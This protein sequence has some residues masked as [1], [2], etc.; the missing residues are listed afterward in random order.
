MSEEVSVLVSVSVEG[1]MLKAEPQ[2][3]EVNQSFSFRVCR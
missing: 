2:W 3:T 1:G